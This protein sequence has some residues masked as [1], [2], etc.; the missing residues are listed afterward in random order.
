MCIGI[1]TSLM[2]RDV[3]PRIEMWRIR[4]TEIIIIIII[5]II[6]TIMIII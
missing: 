4:L 3:E 1:L 5:I 6:I 2:R